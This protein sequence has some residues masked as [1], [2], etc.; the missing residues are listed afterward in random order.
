M[1]VGEECHWWS[2]LFYAQDAWNPGYRRLGSVV[3]FRTNLH[4][5]PKSELAI[6]AS[7]VD[8]LH[9]PR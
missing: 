1:V 7:R 5:P 2:C 4:G 9:A 3:I 8:S 6:D